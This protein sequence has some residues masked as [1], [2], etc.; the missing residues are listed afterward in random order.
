MEG[1]SQFQI[2]STNDCQ[3]KGSVHIA[4]RIPIFIIFEAPNGCFHEQIVSLIYIRIAI[5]S[6]NNT[7]LGKQKRKCQQNQIIKCSHFQK[8][9]P[10]CTHSIKSV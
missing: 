10:A 5:I 2:K 4:A 9:Q 3:W 7:D 6:L 8:G 1:N